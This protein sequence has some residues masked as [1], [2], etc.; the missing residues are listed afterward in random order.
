MKKSKFK[1]GEILVQQGK[2]TEQDVQEALEVQKREGGPIGEVLIR[3]GKLKESDV[4]AALGKQLGVPY[5]GESLGML[6]PTPGQGLENLVP[7]AFAREHGVL[8]LSKHLSSLTVAVADPLDYVTMDNLKRM[9]ACSINPVLAGKTEILKAIDE[10]YGEQNLYQEAV[11]DS[12]AFQDLNSEGSAVGEDALSL[13]GLLALAEQAP[14]M[15]LVDLIIKQAIQDRASDIHIEPFQGRISIRY[16]IDGIL[17]E[18]PPP[19]KHLFAAIV[20]RIK[21]LAG[22]DIAEKRLPQDGGIVV[23][24]EERFIDIRVNTIP[25]VFGEKVCMRL[26]N[27]HEIEMEL[28]QLGF[29]QKEIEILEKGISNPHG[30]IIVTGPTGSGKSATLYALL[31]R[32]KSPR[33]NIVTIEDPVEV[34]IDGLNQVQVKAGI[35]LT[36]SAGLRAFLRQDPDVIMLGE[37]RD[38][39]TAEIAVRAS[40]TGHLVLCTLHTNDALGAITRLVDI[41]VELYLLVSSLVLVEAQRLVRV[42]CPDCREA[43]EFSEEKRLPSI[44]METGIQFEGGGLLYRPKGCEACNNTGYKGR[45]SICEVVPLVDAIREDLGKG[46]VDMPA[47]RKL[48]R[49]LGYRT[50]LESGLQKVVEGSTSLDEVLAATMSV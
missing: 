2:V 6:K 14:V 47:L 11:S 28:N 7:E 50:L 10:F 16:R 19:A 21:V 30:I 27:A 34:K 8:P 48:V 26:M 37:I 9:T 32:L 35:G 12:Y 38:L 22:M 23:K 42:L 1:L 43:Y 45:T 20:S 17:Y 39:E 4:V 36:F 13:D 15:K 3:M 41:G 44:L 46:R 33:K 18:I 29:T 5:A 49:Q 24:S 25:T 31:N 40:L